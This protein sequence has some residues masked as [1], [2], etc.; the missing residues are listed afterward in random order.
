M[1][2]FTLLE[3]LMDASLDAIFIANVNSG[4]IVFANKG[5]CDL[6]GYTATELDGIHQTKLHPSEDCEDIG[7][8]F[9]E[10]VSDSSL[11]ETEARI[12]HKDGHIIPVKITS[13]NLFVDDSI[14]YAAAFFRD[15]R[16]HKDMEK[17]AY[18]QSHVIRRPLANIL[19]LCGLL[20][21]GVFVSDTEIYG[22][23]DNIL[24][25]AQELDDVVK[26]IVKNANH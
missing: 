7:K 3:S 4:N 18:L 21:D 22:A 5:A 25:Q 10:F 16:I 9:K 19:G 11:K 15:I 2:K 26:E 14:L 8:K 1:K 20:N 13:A 23:I 12:I 17:I 24:Q 6:L